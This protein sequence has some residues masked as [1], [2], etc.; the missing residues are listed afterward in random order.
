M[1]KITR[2][3]SFRWLG[4]L[5]GM[6]GLS[7]AA[8]TC[9]L[10]ADIEETVRAWNIGGELESYFATI[11][12]PEWHTAALVKGFSF[13]YHQHIVQD[14]KTGLY[15]GMRPI[16]RLY[17]DQL[18]YSDDLDSY[19]SAFLYG[20]RRLPFRVKCGQE[21]QEFYIRPSAS[22]SEHRHVVSGNMHIRDQVSITFDELLMKTPSGPVT[23]I[24]TLGRP[25]KVEALNPE[26]V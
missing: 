22:A 16:G 19:I 4:G 2:R 8:K 9:E 26:T 25:G 14:T 3:T 18:I 20:H 10:T 15:H 11:N 6:L 24:F 21:V 13:D 17:F 5:L 12:D 23:P 1:T 7:R